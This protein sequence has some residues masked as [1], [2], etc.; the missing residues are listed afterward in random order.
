MKILSSRSSLSLLSSVALPALALAILAVAR[1]VWTFDTAEPGTRVE[2]AAD[3]TL[4]RQYLSKGDAYFKSGDYLNA[5]A[6]YQM[7]VSQN[8]SSEAAK[9]KLQ[10]TMELLRSQKAQNILFDVAISAADKLFQAGDYDRALAEYENAGK[11]LPSDPYP[12]NRINEILKRKVDRKVREEEYGKAIVNADKAYNAKNWQGA[13]LDY[14]K[15]LSIKP[16]EKYPQD[17]TTELETLI[18]E[19]KARDEA[20]GKAIAEADLSFSGKLYTE[21]I[22]SYRE[23]LKVKP[24]QLYPRDRIREAEALIARIAKAQADYERYVA[25]ADSFYIDKQYLKARENYLAASAAKPA[26][27]YPKEMI[28][29]ADRMLTGQEAAMARALDEQYARTIAGADKLLA[30]RQLEPARAEY[31]RAANLKPAE[32]YP[33]DKTAEIDG[34]IANALKD[35]EER[36]KQALDDGDRALAGRILELARSHYRAALDMKPAES[37]PKNKL[38]EVDKLLAAE[39]AHKAADARYANSLGRADSLFLEKAYLASKAEFQNALKMKP[40]E[41]YPKN[42][43]R[44][45]DDLIGEMERLK[46]LDSQ[47][48]GVIARADKLFAERSWTLAR[49]EYS[50]AAAL[51]PGES[52][53]ATKIAAIDQALAAVDAEKRSLEEN[54]RAMIGKGDSLLALKSYDPARF[55]YMNASGLKPSEAYPKKKIAEIDAALSALRDRENSYLAA[56]KKGEGLLSGKSYLPAKAAFQ[57]ALALKPG[58]VYPQE[59]IASIDSALETMAA[60]KALD[61]KYA[62]ILAGADKLL[63]AKDYLQA[64]PAYEQALGVKP[65]EPYPKEKVAEIDRILA[66]LDAMKALDERYKTAI[67]AGDDQLSAKAYEPAR[68]QYLKAAELKPAESY[69]KKKIGEIDAV[70]A[71][72]AQLKALNEEY[73]ALVSEGDKLFGDKAYEAAKSKF[74]SALQRKPEEQYPKDKMAEIDRK[75]AELAAIRDRDDRYAAAVKNGDQLLEQK[76]YSPAREAYTEALSLKPEE[77]YPKKKISE[78]DAALEALAA[79]RALDEKYAGF[80]AA[81]DRQ[82]VAREYVQARTGYQQAL[83]LK[84]GE[85]YPKEKIAEIGRTLADLE[86]ARVLDEKY[87]ATVAEGDRLLAARS[88]EQAKIS[89]TTAAGLKPAEEYP[90]TKIAEI[91]VTLAEIARLKALDEEYSGTV[92]AADRSFSEKSYPEAKAS[93]EKAL[94]LKPAESYPKTR[95]SEI[96]GIMAEAER[97]K[98]IDERYVAAIAEADRLLLAKSYDE[99]RR[100]YVEAGKIKPSD[101]YP[102]TKIT[103]ID[104]VLEAMARQ[105]ALDDR[106]QA[107][108]AKADQLLADRSLE[109]ARTEYTNAQG[110]K[111][112]EKYPKEKIGEIDALL[113]EIKAREE[114]Y[115]GVLATADNLLA[116]KKYDAAKPEYQ[117]ALDMK[118]QASYPREKLAEID[119]ALEELLGKQKYYEN[120]ITDADR[121]FSGKDY[122]RA[123]EVYQQAL[124]VFPSEAYPKQRIAMATARID[125]LYRA[126]KAGYDKAV[127]DGDRFYNTYEFDKAVDAYTEAANLLPMEKYPREMI[128]KIR[129]TIEENAIV[130]VLKTPTTITSNNE[131]Q[132]TFTPVN[133]ASRKNNFLYIRIRNLSGKSFNVLMRYGKGKQANGGVVMRNLSVDGKMNE[134]LVSVRDQDLW[135]R[136]DNNWISLY[137]QG[138][139]VEVSFIQVSR[140]V[141]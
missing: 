100:A 78:I 133:V 92:A 9:E 47:Y 86:A 12:K 122:P 4:A 141:Q 51:K 89:Y 134:R 82:W 61:E 8:P 32:Q 21:S 40:E 94:S 59:K 44:E 130:D 121:S 73:A 56:I 46:K 66:E 84:P 124:N 108:L 60:A 126:N 7:A 102:K 83:E 88:Y 34:L 93:Y 16:G 33:K 115:R 69:P 136:E 110:L 41:I 2:A 91:G 62:G 48:Q 131:K 129:R 26:E 65:G 138:G 75:L 63:A 114:A 87:A 18:A 74:Q 85:A 132:F 24:E 20:Y 3:T 68:L 55:E 45:I 116:Q 107:S 139:D 49:A 135:S 57:E 119:K 105:K 97:L 90:K 13:L 123:K 31:V 64:R 125:S 50:K 109:A 117:R 27:N 111:P 79:A 25:L 23:A 99:A 81:A 39:A 137:P 19:Q 30:D 71:E 54:Y 70:L 10:R 104:A 29:K 42:R 5:K 103:E 106:Y 1:P 67:A 17:R 28:A 101:A 52:Y 38:A 140:A 128:L 95:L 11:L 127:A 53:P 43:I 77:S 72:L 120:L 36:Y 37:Y 58:E 35:K 15:A 98:A 113:A 6:S 96:G 14:R 118:P 76:S 22:R 80:I 112:E